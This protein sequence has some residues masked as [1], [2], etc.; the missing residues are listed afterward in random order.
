MDLYPDIFFVYYSAHYLPLFRCKTKNLKFFLEILLFRNI[1]LLSI[2]LKAGSIL[3][4]LQ[5][6]YLQTN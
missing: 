5:V 4:P 2:Q 1:S 6:I 3:L